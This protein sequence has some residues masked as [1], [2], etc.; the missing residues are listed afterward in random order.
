[1]E[2][3]GY[4]PSLSNAGEIRCGFLLHGVD[5]PDDTVSLQQ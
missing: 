1:M 2:P 3:P 4:T 5:D